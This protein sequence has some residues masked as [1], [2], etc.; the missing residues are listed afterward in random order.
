[1]KTNVLIPALKDGL[2]IRL[3]GALNVVANVINAMVE[4]KLA[5]IVKRT[6]L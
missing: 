3:D 2:K 5:L 4:K 6:Q 1:M